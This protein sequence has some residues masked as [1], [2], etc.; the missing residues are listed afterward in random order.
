[1][2]ST[3]ALIDGDFLLY[4]A[5][6]PKKESVEDK[7]VLVPKSF[8]EIQ[9]VVK[10]Y[11]SNIVEVL[12]TPYYIGALSHRN[13]FRKKYDP[14]YKANRKNRD[15][16]PF[17]Y[18]LKDLL[19]R[20]YKFVSVPDLE[21]DDIVNILKHSI[22]DYECVIVSNDTDVLSLEGTHYNP[23]KREFVTTTK[24]EALRKFW[25]DMITGQFGDNI[26]GLP[27]RGPAFVEKLFEIKEVSVPYH[28]LVLS[29]YIVQMGE[30]KGIDEFYKN[31]KS[32][33]ILKEYPDMVIPE[34]QMFAL[35]L[36]F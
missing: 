16:P 31:Y 36:P 13:N 35:R 17:Y 15:K 29:A 24:E 5:T 28:Q 30:E 10:V 1:M 21:A 18:Q 3:L 19:I 12:S 33:K 27:G 8:D 25:S 23:T 11:L 14:E 22:M 20:E 4:Y 32:L 9:E 7:I 6:Y 34:P 26:K 2:K